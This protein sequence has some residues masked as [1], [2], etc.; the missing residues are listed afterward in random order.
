MAVCVL[1]T[2]S[3]A[4]NTAAFPGLQVLL[5]HRKATTVSTRAETAQGGVGLRGG[6]NLYK[7]AALVRGI[8]EKRKNEGGIEGQ[9]QGE[10]EGDGERGEDDV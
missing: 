6:S 4:S 7:G 5:W 8:K 10:Y 2:F 9:R 3:R 1:A